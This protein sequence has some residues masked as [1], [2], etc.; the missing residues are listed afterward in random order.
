VRRIGELL[1]G[2]D[3]IPEFV[4]RTFSFQPTTSSGSILNGDYLTVPSESKVII[5]SHGFLGSRF[6]LSHIAEELASR[7]FVCVSPEYP[8]SLAASY[9]RTTGLDRQVINNELLKFVET[10]IQPTGYGVVG[11]SL[12]CGTALSLGDSTWARVLIA[13]PPAPKDSPSPLL[14]ITSMNDIFVQLRGSAAFVPPPLRTI[15][16]G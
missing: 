11:H 1:A 5:L 6:D 8:E 13:G 7:G 3:F 9:Q 10:T 2:W 16:G 4:S 15:G 12:G 14:F